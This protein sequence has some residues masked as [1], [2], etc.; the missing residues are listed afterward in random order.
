MLL[1]PA[2]VF[3]TSS[4]F[5]VVLTAPTIT[6]HRGKVP[7]HSMGVSVLIELKTEDNA[8]KKASSYLFWKFNVTILFDMEYRSKGVV[9][10]D[11]R[12]C[13]SCRALDIDEPYS[14]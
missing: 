3:P 7:T 13:F 4:H 1:L 9:G 8:Y 6:D 12:H 2:P 11:L 5:I 10:N 14:N